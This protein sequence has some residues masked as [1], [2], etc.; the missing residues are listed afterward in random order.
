[1]AARLMN[2]CRTWLF[3]FVLLAVAAVL[4]CGGGGSAGTPVCAAGASVACTCT[5]GT[6]GA[7]VC[8]SSGLGYGAC[9]CSEGSGGTVGSGG[10]LGSGGAT[11]SGGLP[12]SAGAVGTGG[13]P[14]SGGS[15]AL[16]GS[17]GSGGSGVGGHAGSGAAGPTGTGGHAPDAGASL[18]DGGSADGGGGYSGR[19][20]S[21]QIVDA[22]IGPAQ[23]AEGTPWDGPGTVDPSIIEDVS[24]ALVG[25]N[26]AAAV[27][28][29]LANPALAVFDPP[30]PYG[31]VQATAF[32]VTGPVYPGL[33][34]S[35]NPVP[36]T[37]NPIW[38]NGGFEYTG[39][40]IDS[41]VRIT[42]SL[43]DSDL[44]FDDTIG[45]AVI[46]SDDFKAAL[47]AKQKYEVQVSDQ[48]NNLLLFIGIEVVEQAAP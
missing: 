5:N 38:P 42:V 48:T 13:L 6:T 10:V 31:T 44:V 7:Q 46:N 29:I 45:T 21:V 2:P 9:T 3:S 33:A 20:V 34:T 11:G 30:D 24:E 32:G 40:P 15:P 41:D 26:P 27:L 4:G 17:S 37:Y 23:D 12:G 28:A 19:W 18:S 14:G 39:V 16:G 47:A 36:N 43:W 22:I 25:A 8:T 1:V 35:A